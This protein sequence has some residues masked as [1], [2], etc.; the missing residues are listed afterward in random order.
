[1]DGLDRRGLLRLLA[2]VGAAGVTGG[3]AGCASGTVETPKSTIRIGL[4]VPATG[5]NKSI[6]ADLENGFKLFLEQEGG[7]LS[8]HPVDLVIQDEGDT[9]DT[10]MRALAEL[11][12]EKVL[13]VVGVAN[14]L[15]LPQIRD[16][17][18]K[19]QIPLLATHGSPTDMANA[20]YIWRTAYMHDEPG[21]AAGLYLQGK[22]KVALVRLEEDKF[23]KEAMEG[24]AKE[25][26]KKPGNVTSEIV[27]PPIG[28]PDPARL[29]SAAQ[30]TITSEAKSVFCHLPAAYLVAYW[31]AL[32]EAGSELNIYAPG[33]VSE[34]PAV[35]QLDAV[36]G[37]YTV[38]HYSADL[39]NAANRSFSSVFQTKF[40][41][42]P[43]AYAVAAYDAALVLNRAITL[44]GDR[45]VTSQLVN[46]EIANIGQ[47]IS[48]RGNWQFKDN[49]QAPQQTWY[50]RQ[51]RMD[52]PLLS[53]VLV[54]EL[55]PLADPAG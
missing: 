9:V 47:V 49:T 6:G 39:N 48:P 36:K 15:L 25:F 26:A 18:E 29:A 51:I 31:Q 2:G 20:L 14:P 43:T 19:S 35:D 23:G 37:L 46:E 1:M 11:H 54:S 40:T 8:G 16:A 17:V 12:H 55:V 10:G 5:V 42:S 33:I 44:I 50:L 21:R 34:G 3:L 45:P 52:G 22:G 27:V 7:Q 32:R 38:M 13:A 4:L 30:N 28:N 41:R 53:N 24:F